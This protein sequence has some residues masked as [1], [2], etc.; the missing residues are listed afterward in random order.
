MP[1]YLM[2]TAQ[3]L[4]LVATGS[5]VVGPAFTFFLVFSLMPTYNRSTFNHPEI[6]VDN[7]GC[8]RYTTARAA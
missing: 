4:A 7:D 1:H 3:T 5:L 6:N 2:P 8:S